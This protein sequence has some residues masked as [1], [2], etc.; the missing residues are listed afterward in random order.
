MQPFHTVLTLLFRQ[1]KGRLIQSK[2]CFCFGL[3]FVRAAS[4]LEDATYL[5]IH[6]TFIKLEYQA[7]RLKIIDIERAIG[8]ECATHAEGTGMV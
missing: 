6:I 8:I 1:E 3:V 2:L 7:R 4:G 5:S